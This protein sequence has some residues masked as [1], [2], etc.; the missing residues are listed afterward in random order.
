MPS[1][2]HSTVER[3]RARRLLRAGGGS[4]WR[5]VVAACVVAL[6]LAAS[7]GDVFADRKD[8]A[9]SLFTAAKADVDA[10]QL[11]V[12]LGKLDR[13]ERLFGHPA[14]R[15]LR[16][17]VLRQLLMLD[18]AK[19][20]MD[21]VPTRTKAARKLRSEIRAERR[22]LDDALSK[23]GALTVDV[24]PLDPAL[25][26]KV[27]D[28]EIE[29]DADGHWRAWRPVGQVRVEAFAPGFT[30]VVRSKTVVAGEETRVSLTLERQLGEIVVLVPGGL[31]GVEVALD[32][33]PWTI[34]GA[35][36][37]GD[38]TPPR[39]VPI[40][41]HEVSCT[42]KRKRAA[43]QVTVAVDAQT[44]VTCQGLEPPSNTGRKV[45]GWSGVGVGAGLAGAGGFLLQSYFADVEKAERENLRLQTN[46]HAYAATFLVT[47]IAGGLAS[48]W[49]LVRDKPEQD[50]VARG[51]KAAP[52][53]RFSVVPLAGTGQ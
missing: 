43:Q 10:G 4:L 14:I 7:P 5:R 39:K 33:E 45:A 3:A 36:R 46:K 25:K 51:P 23:H 21:A 17:R 38:R 44:V 31:R 34:D 52:S 32:G 13:A 9:Y 18:D 49:F 42:R 2:T 15:L 41:K 11:D 37:A 40:G 24:S 16:V 35:V 27:G 6:T 50:A 1:L 29:L 30:P 12:A 20:A 19:A 26:V 8:R 47:G 53:F 28:A 22:A 48:Y